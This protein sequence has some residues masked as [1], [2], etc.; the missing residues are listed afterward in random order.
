MNTDNRFEITPTTEESDS[1]YI[2]HTPNHSLTIHFDYAVHVSNGDQPT[3]IGLYKDGLPVS[4]V[5]VSL[6]DEPI[7]TITELLL[8]ES[9]VNK[10]KQELS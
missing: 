10:V 7:D 8:N 4:S 1:N 9:D 6:I 3:E 2:L 5:E